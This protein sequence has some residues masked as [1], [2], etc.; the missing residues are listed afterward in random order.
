MNGRNFVFSGQGRVAIGLSFPQQPTEVLDVNGNQRLRQVPEQGGESLI[1]GLQQG[2]NADDIEFSRLAF[3][4]NTNDVLLGDGAWGTVGGG[5]TNCDDITGA[6]NL[7]QDSKVNLNNHQLYFELNDQPGLNHTGFGYTCYDFLPTKVSVRQPH[8]MTLATNSTAVYGEN[9]DIGNAVALNY[10]AV[11]GEAKG[12][13]NPLLRI[14]NIGGDFSAAQSSLNTGVRSYINI[15]VAFSPGLFSLNIGTDNRVLGPGETNI[16]GRF[17]AV[18][19]ALYNYGVNTA[20]A[21]SASPTTTNYALWAFAPTAPNHYAGFFTGDV[22]VNGNLAWTSDENLKENTNT[23]TD[24][25][26]VIEQLNP[27][28]FEFKQTGIY[29]RMNMPEGNQFGMLAQEVEQILP[30]LVGTS[31]FPAEFDSLGN[32]TAAAIE[33]KTMNYEAL[34]PILTKVLQE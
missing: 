33:F 25:M 27:V 7:T 31:I 23:I 11:K 12:V 3:T 8:P 18:G 1:L 24:A 32:E 5:F 10:A 15:P 9:T 28:S 2:T 16:A 34:I 21:L 20:V 30:E 14:T 29:E 19:G 26:S 22:M 6:E 13:Q 4:G 17:S